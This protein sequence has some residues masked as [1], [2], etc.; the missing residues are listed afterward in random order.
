MHNKEKIILIIILVLIGFII[1][2]ISTT[3]TKSQFVRL[4]DVFIFSPLLIYAGYLLYDTNQI[5]AIILIIIGAATAAYN[6]KIY[7]EYKN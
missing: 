3:G 2:W 1:G 7:A 6:F 5:L 4:L